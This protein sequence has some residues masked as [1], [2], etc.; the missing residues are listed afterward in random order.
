MRCHY[1]SDIHLD[2][3]PFDGKLAEGDVLI[4]AGDLC[5]ASCLD[6]VRKD[7][8]A[9]NQRS[10]VLSLIEHATRN[11]D[12]VLVIAG[13]HEH[14]DGSFNDTAAL[15]RTHLPGVTVLDNETVEV[16]GVRFFGSTLW[17]DFNGGS[18]RAMDHVRRKIGDYFFVAAPGDNKSTKPTKF[19]PEDAL[20][21]HRLSWDALVSAVA[22]EPDK[23]TVIVSHHAPSH[24]GLN[25]RF[26]GNG[27][28]PAF[29]SSLDEEIAQ[30]ENVPVWVHGHTHVAKTYQIG[31]TTVRSNALGFA[32]RGHAA[33]G[34][35]LNASFEVG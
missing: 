9:V 23:D 30:F 28:D 10:R 33:P 29:A 7:R 5:N 8:Y 19:Q 25:R 15:M 13:N 3:Q 31:R 22:A 26:F 12:E 14:Y 6:Q 24:L 11:F 2:A 35:N 16:G 32:E 21:Q 27:L 34:F 18:Q 20:A 17:T 1:L 4:I